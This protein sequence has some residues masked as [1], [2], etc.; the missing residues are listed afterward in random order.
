MKNDHIDTF[1]KNKDQ[2]DTN[3]FLTKSKLCEFVRDQKYSF[4][5]FFWLGYYKRPKLLKN[6]FFKVFG[7]IMTLVM[8]IWN[9]DSFKIVFVKNTFKRENR[10]SEKHFLTK[11]LYFSK[12]SFL[13][14]ISDQNLVRKCLSER[15]F[16]RSKVSFTKTILN[17]FTF[18]INITRLMFNP[19]TLKNVF[20]SKF[21][22]LQAGLYF[23]TNFFFFF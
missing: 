18:Q 11:I 16:S 7:L 15:H 5:F 2:H 8:F 17:K 19:K 3:S 13:K 10:L 14:T 4:F 20:F 12:S 1:E 6:T 22:L 21:S 23:F 9:I